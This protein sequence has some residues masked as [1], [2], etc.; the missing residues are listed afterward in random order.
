MFEIC[1]NCVGSM[2]S[3]RNFFLKT[4]ASLR[5]RGNRAQQCKLRKLSRGLESSDD[6]VTLRHLNLLLSYA[7]HL[8]WFNMLWHIDEANF[9]LTVCLDF[10]PK[11]CKFVRYSTQMPAQWFACSQVE[12]IHGAMMRDARCRV[13]CGWKRIREISFTLMIHNDLRYC[14]I[15]FSYVDILCT[16][17]IYTI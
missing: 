9:L 7:W 13:Q 8:T 2:S 10:F 11:F 4:C 3:F 1:W 6:N 17:Y 12:R 15:Y 5:Q 14:N 16:Y